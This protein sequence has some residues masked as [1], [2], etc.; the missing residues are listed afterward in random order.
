MY[1]PFEDFRLDRRCVAVIGSGGKTTFLRR[2]AERLPGTVLLTT[3]THIFPLAGV[4][5]VDTGAEDAPRRPDDI[6]DALRSALAESRVACLGRKLPSGKLASPEHALPFEALLSA[7]DFVLVEADGAAGRPLKAH[8]PFE[9]VIPSCAERTVC[10]VGA[11]GL[12]KP[13]HEACHCP[14]LFAERAGMAPGEPVGEAQLARVLNGEDLADVY[15]VNQVDALP[16]PS[17]ALRLCA[18]I[19]KAAHPCA[20]AR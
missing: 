15:L 13:V 7:A 3:S 6:L 16:D 8:R 1:R 14:E 12:G 17:R 20:L 4:P 5:L 2:M 19:A 10:L 18:L 11:S 9:P